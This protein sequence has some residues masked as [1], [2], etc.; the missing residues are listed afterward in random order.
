MAWK[1]L[2]ARTVLTHRLILLQIV[3]TGT[4]NAIL[5]LKDHRVDRVLWDLLVD[6]ASVDQQAH[7]GLQVNLDLEAH[8]VHLDLLDQLALEVLAECQATSL[9]Q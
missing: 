7:Q 2:L 8:L 5:L 6:E 9:K 3:S 4:S 1:A